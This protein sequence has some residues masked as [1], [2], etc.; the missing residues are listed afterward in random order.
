MT[1]TTDAPEGLDLRK[2]GTVW[3]YLD[4]DE[5][6]DK[7]VLVK[8]RRPKMKELRHLR[9][10]EWAIAAEL[11]EFIAPLQDQVDA[12]LGQH[13][14]DLAD[15]TTFAKKDTH[16]LAALRDLQR[17]RDQQA[18]LHAEKLRGPWAAEVIELLSE[19]EVDED[20]LPPW[21]FGADFAAHLLG[22]WLTVP[23]RRGSP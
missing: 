11:R 3:L 18:T 2:D 17:E 15:P 16:V 10:A 20:D 9:E 22:H 21:C 5:R 14:I 19:T 13:D 7:T 8:I 12:Y 1:T 4:D 6:P 23:T